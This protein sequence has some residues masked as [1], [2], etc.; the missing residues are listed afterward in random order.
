MNP[1]QTFTTCE[2]ANTI[3]VL[4]PTG[5]IGSL[6]MSVVFC[7][8]RDS[9]VSSASS[10][11]KLEI[12]PGRMR[13]SAGTISP[14]WRRI[15]S[16]LNRYSENDDNTKRTVNSR[17]NSL[18]LYCRNLSFVSLPTCMSQDSSYRTSDAFQSRNSLP[19]TLSFH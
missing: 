3:Q 6:M 9:P 16:P 18:N 10:H 8:G 1:I 19:S 7:T 13:A 11:C 2:P 5:Q 15:M 14:A 17:Y 4:S 12:Y